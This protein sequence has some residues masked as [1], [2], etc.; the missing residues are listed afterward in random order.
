MP[1]VISVIGF[2]GSS[3][4]VMT[5]I[6][7]L[8]AMGLGPQSLILLTVDPDDANGN[9]KELESVIKIYQDCQNSLGFDRGASPIFSTHI[10]LLEGE[11]NKTHLNWCPAQVGDNLNN[12][13]QLNEMRESGEESTRTAASLLSSLYS[14]DELDLRW[15]LGFRGHPSIGAPVMAK[16]EG[17]VRDQ[18]KPRKPWYLLEE[19]IKEAVQGSSNARVFIVGSLF[20]ATG[21]SGIPTLSKILRHRSKEWG[22]RQKLLLGGCFLLPY[23]TYSVPPNTDQPLNVYARPEYFCLNTKSTLGFY[24]L[25]YAQASPYNAI[26]FMGESLGQKTQDFAIG[27]LKARNSAH[28]V[29]LLGALAFIHFFRY[30]SADLEENANKLEKVKLFV[31]ARDAGNELKWTDLPESESLKLLP[32]TVNFLTMGFAVQ[33]FYY[34][35]IKDSRFERTKNLTPWYFLDS[36][37]REQE[38]WLSGRNS[39]ESFKNFLKY[40]HLLSS[41]LYELHSTPPEVTVSLLSKEIINHIEENLSE[42]PDKIKR[43]LASNDILKIPMIEPHSPRDNGYAQ[44]WDKLCGFSPSDLSDHQNPVGRFILNLYKA[45]EI[46]N[47]RH[48]GWR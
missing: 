29:D 43:T 37:Y 17:A 18:R 16:I 9:L 48:Y 40:F 36:W 23:F 45:C 38:R 4:R 39:L 6:V 2:G 19:K 1:E 13:M 20:G 14:S 41:W 30:P 3:A 5:S 24:D 26:Y 27:G 42:E 25:E 22:N 12:Y 46:V 47:K 28:F 8:C 7:H 31:S 32:I 33:S 34:P 15:D 44:I 35:L 10:V 11:D 21:S